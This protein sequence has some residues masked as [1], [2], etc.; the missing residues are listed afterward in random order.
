MD[1]PAT[2]GHHVHLDV[3]WPVYGTILDGRWDLPVRIELHE[4]PA[5]A[6]AVYLR[7]QAYSSDEY[8]RRADLVVPLDAHR[9]GVR[10]FVLPLDLSSWPTGSTEFR[11]SYQV[12]YTV[13]GQERVQRQSTGLQACIRTCTSP[14]RSLPWYEARG[15]YEKVGDTNHGYQV[16]RL[17]SEPRCLRS[18]GLCKV[19]M[20]PGSGGLPTVE[21]WAVLSPNFHGGSAGTVILTRDGPYSGNITLPTLAPGS[22][23]LVLVASDGEN[24][25]VATFGFVV[26]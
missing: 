23:R 20:K 4:V 24:A 18:G 15:Y 13:D 6:T 7:A 22:Y 8:I 11:F 2:V 19:E 21:S 17:R 26:P 25:G 10:D 14:D 5:D 12:E 16:A 9:N 1:I 3:C